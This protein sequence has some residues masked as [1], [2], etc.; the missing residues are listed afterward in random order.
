MVA[1][2]RS[3]WYWILLSFAVYS[4][5]RFIAIS[6]FPARRQGIIEKVKKTADA[7]ALELEDAMQKDLQ[8]TTENLEK[9]VRII[10]EPYGDAAQDRLDK[11]L[12]IKDELSNVRETL[13]KLQVEIQNLHLS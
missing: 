6:N 4:Y 3:V 7:L 11:L 10:G 9:F 13:Q 1:G 5:D 12:E 8:E 2:L